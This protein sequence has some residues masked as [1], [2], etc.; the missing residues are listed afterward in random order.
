MKIG[1]VGSGIAGLSAAWLLSRRHDVTVFE[2]EER[3]GGHTATID[4]SLDGERHAIDT[5]FIVFNDRTYPN[6]IRLMDELGVTSQPT[7]MSF[8]V[9][10]ESEGVEYAGRNLDSLFAQRGNLLRPA[11]WRMLRDILRFNRN[12]AADLEHGRIPEGMLLGDYLARN[13]YSREFRDWYLVPMGAAIWSSGTRGM[14]EFPVEFFVRFFR[15]HGLLTVTDQ[16]Q[17]RTIRGGSREYLGPLTRRFA[18]AIR[19]GDPVERI[20]READGVSVRT[21][22]GTSERF[23][24]VVLGC[25][26]DQALA[27]LGDPS[28]EERGILSSIP[29]RDNDV[30]LHTDTRVLPRS[31][32]AWSSWNYRL[33]TGADALPVLSYDMNILQ[34]LESRHTFCVTLNDTAAIDPSRILGRYR[35]SHPV[36]SLEGVRAQQR[37]AEINGVRRTWFCGAW[38]ANGFHEDGVASALRVAEALGAPW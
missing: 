16:P 29:Y 15:N 35:Y 8:S 17:W 28:A 27:L 36:F 1:I 23:E 9:S 5:G 10:S 32:R 12:A 14:A 18:G 30:V 31:P 19:T 38:W 4:V 25:H 13:G 34:R 2:A 11:F 6:F 20:T 21:R 24:H 26:S 7:E 37:W 22:G 3:I 33:R